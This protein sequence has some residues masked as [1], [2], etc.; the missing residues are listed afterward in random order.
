[1]RE[2]VSAFDES[3]FVAGEWVQPK[4]REDGVIVIGSWDASDVVGRWERALYDRH[5]V[6]PESDYLSDEFAEIMRRFLDDPLS[7]WRRI[8]RPFARS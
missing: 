7:C 4:R 2:F 8:W 1:M 5:I 6:D 3:A